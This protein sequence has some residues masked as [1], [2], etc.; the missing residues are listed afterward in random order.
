MD[1]HD[2]VSVVEIILQQY[3]PKTVHLPIKMRILEMFGSSIE[4]SWLILILIFNVLLFLIWISYPPAKFDK[5]VIGF[6]HPYWYIYLSV[7]R[8]QNLMIFA[9]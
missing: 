1:S 2:F 5:H 7:I 8:L 4:Y 6:F 9:P 3:T